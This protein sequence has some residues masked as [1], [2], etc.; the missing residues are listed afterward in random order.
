MDPPPPT[1]EKLPN[2]G[3]RKEP[4][5]S[6]CRR[7]TRSNTRISTNLFGVP[8]PGTRT[9]RYLT[10]KKMMESATVAQLKSPEATMPSKLDSTTVAQLKS[11]EATMPSMLDPTATISRS[12]AQD[13]ID[14][15]NKMSDS[16]STRDESYD[17]L[18]RISVSSDLIRSLNTTVNDCLLSPGHP[19][20]AVPDLE[21]LM[22]TVKTFLIGGQYNPEN[23]NNLP[24]WYVI[25]DC[26]FLISSV[27]FYFI[28]VPFSGCP[29]IF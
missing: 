4:S 26:Q 21:K 12:C 8:D 10:S 28:F 17:D 18:E 6:I 13:L 19:L 5:N 11:P 29:S 14:T 23:V 9:K 1:V 24:Q 22:R 15:V 3:K 20:P 16:L 7:S 27:S 2:D 25:C